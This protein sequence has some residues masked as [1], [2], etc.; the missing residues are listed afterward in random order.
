MGFL[1]S[2]SDMDQDTILRRQATKSKRGGAKPAEQASLRRAAARSATARPLSIP[3]GSRRPTGAA[4]FPALWIQ[5]TG[6]A[7][8]QV[9]RRRCPRPDYPRHHCA[10][11]LLATTGAVATR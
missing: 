7:P 2:G 4:A 6:A 5:A 11:G 10:A 1:R 3:F 8:V 9:D